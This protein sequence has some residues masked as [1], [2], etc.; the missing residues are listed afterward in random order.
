MKLEKCY[1]GG[2]G[3]SNLTSETDECGNRTTRQPSVAPEMCS[4][5]R[6]IP[7]RRIG[8][9][10]RHLLALHR[11]FHG[12]GHQFLYNQTPGA[13]LLDA[14]VADIVRC[15][16]GESAHPALRGLERHEQSLDYGSL[17][18]ILILEASGR[19]GKP[20]DSLAEPRA[21][22]LRHVNVR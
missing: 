3:H 15:A 19:G 20:T 4:P 2:A 6:R 17:S 12:W 21:D 13:S 5:R 22:F 8:R 1:E 11:A 18:H 16:F 9:D 7:N 10:R 14:G